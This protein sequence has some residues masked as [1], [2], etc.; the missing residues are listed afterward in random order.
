VA[1][2][3]V[4]LKLRLLRNALRQSQGAKVTF[5]LSTFFAGV[6]AVVTFAG[7]AALRG[8]AAAVDV[9][10]VVFTVFA[11]GWLILPLLVFGLD[12]TL[13]PATLALYPLRTRPLAVGLL[14]ASATGAWPLANLIGL[15][16]VTV[17]LAHGPAGLAVAVL[18]TVLELLF[19]IT[20]ARLVTTALAGVLRSR[21]GRDFAAL[22]ILPIFALYET[23]VQVVPRM[24]AEGKVTAAS[25]AGVGGWLR[26][27]P[28]GL[29]A[30]AIRDASAGRAGP[31]LVRLALLAAI[32]VVLGGLWV[33]ALDRGLVTTDASTR[34][35]AVHGTALPFARGGLRGTVAAR[36]WVYQRR[37]PGSLIYWGITAVVM[38]AASVS[39][40]RTPSY[41]AAVIGSAGFG[42]A[43]VGVFHANAIGMTGPAFGLETLAL[44]GPRGLRAYFSGQ[45]LALG[46]IAVP[47]LVAISFV[48][49][50]VAGHP[51]A[52][53][54]G[55]AVDLAGIGMGLALGNI[56]SA[57]LPY[58]AER[59]VGNPTPRAADGFTGRSI[60]GVVGCLI[61]VAL[62]V[63]PV[64]TVGEVTR[65]EPALA[66]IPLLLAG[67]AAY[68]LVLAWIGVRAAAR[69]AAP[70]LPELYQ[71]AVRSKL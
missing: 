60:L 39:T 32:I 17:G 41:L 59:R 52:G 42:A 62:A 43:F 45:D 38:G 11:F 56:F 46:L 50:T 28:P 51:A 47:L 13:D 68:G 65:P 53:F 8:Q 37:E 58:P 18:A 16:G 35:A 66:R 21:R 14:A 27:I 64:V 12:S 33:R 57:A 2:L 10:A 54:L 26:W 7:L 61:G 20:A 69:V 1:R 5:I 3:L 15:L 71:L 34:S 9:T 19:C 29:A 55:A 22:L 44:S 31:A 67:A 70:R 25:F 30:Y 49:A 48:I 24:T 23:F 36:F 6:V 40:I 63:S 4:Q